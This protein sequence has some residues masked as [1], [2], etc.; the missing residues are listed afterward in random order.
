M[1]IREKLHPVERSLGKGMEIKAGSGDR[2]HAA[3]TQGQCM[4]VIGRKSVWKVHLG[5]TKVS[6]SLL[7]V[8]KGWSGY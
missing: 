5:K 4:G 2:C 6:D 8:I 1:I 7:K 3:V